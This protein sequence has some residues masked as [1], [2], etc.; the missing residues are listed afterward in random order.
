MLPVISYLITAA[1]Y[2]IHVS[3]F[4]LIMEKYR[5]YNFAF[6]AFFFLIGLGLLKVKKWAYYS[7]L[8]FVICFLFY[9]VWILISISIPAFYSSAFSKFTKADILL[10][11]SAIL[12]ILFLIVYFLHRE[13]SSPY[14]GITKGWRISPRDTL[15]IKFECRIGET[16]YQKGITENI[17]SGGCFLITEDFQQNLPE[18]GQLI[19]LNLFL[20]E[21]TSFEKIT[22]QGEV[23]R[24]RDGAPG[25]KRGAGIR[26]VF[27]K[28]SK[29]EKKKLESY[30]DVK[31]APRFKIGHP[32]MFRVPQAKEASPG[33]LFNISW[34]GMYIESETI[35]ETGFRIT[36]VITGA[37]TPFNVEGRV[38]WVNPMGKYSKKKGFGIQI[39]SVKE[40]YLWHLWLL[41]LSY[42]AERIR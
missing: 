9:C 14:L 41:K 24:V 12:V 21:E 17:S 13:I 28:K 38:A 27:D 7:F 40:K 16:P 33:K 42:H 32:V 34:G 26:F 35:P 6:L 4:F 23:V 8:G 36:V 25:I 1:Y 18:A 39:D 31:Y 3:H 5:I 29:N 22:V 20:E 19:L 11:I 2:S 30:L 37:L 15:P 10:N